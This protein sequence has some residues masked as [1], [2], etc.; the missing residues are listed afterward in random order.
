MSDPTHYKWSPIAQVMRLALRQPEPWLRLLR[1]SRGVAVEGQQMNRRVE[2]VVAVANLLGTG[3]DDVDTEHVDVCKERRSFRRTATLGMP[4][5]TDVHTTDKTIPGPAGP[6]PVRI[7]QP[8]CEPAAAILYLHGGGWTVG[9]LDTHDPTCRMLAGEAGTTVVAVDYRLAPEHPFPAALDDTVA[10]YEWL[11]A[12]TS[13]LGVETG[14]VAVGGDSAGG[15]LAAAA[16]LAARDRGLVMPVAQLLIYPGLDMRLT[17]PSIDLFADGFLLTKARMQWFRS[18]YVADPDEYANALASPLLAADL[19]G[20]PP[21]LVAI[22]GMDPLRDEASAYAE[23]LAAAG[24]PVDLR[25][26]D[27]FVHGFFAMGVVPECFDAS[28]KICRD[29]GRLVRESAQLRR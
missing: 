25:C 28:R 22:A 20:V 16:C 15:N 29:F 8:A 21:A 7:F 19:S 26:F 13:T 18:N 1:R 14:A 2:L 27:G 3:L 23:R 4:V 24:V 9:D 11:Q 5:R 17:S 12:N 6:L 10:A